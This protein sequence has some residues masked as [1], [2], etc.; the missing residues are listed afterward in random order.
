MSKSCTYTFKGPDGKEVS[1]TG[2]PAMKAYLATGG[3]EF[4][5]GE[6]RADLARASANDGGGTINPSEN[7]DEQAG[8]VRPEQARDGGGRYSSGGLAPLEG[9]PSV[10]GFHGPDPRLVEV[11]ERYAADN[12]IPLRRQAEYVKVDPER[13]ARI[14]GAYDAME[15]A[16]QDPAVRE[17]YESLIQQTR[18]QYDALADAGYSFWFVDL[19]NQGNLDYVST[20]WNAMRDIRANRRMGVFPTAEGFGT[21]ESFDPDANPLLADTGLR[22]PVGGPGGPL[23]PVLANDLF[24]AVHDAFGHGLEGAGFRARGEENAWQAHVRL[25]TGSAIGAIT[26]E[27]RGQNSWLNFGPYGERNRAA[28]VEDTVF[29]DQKTGLMPEWTWTEG[30]APD[31]DAEVAKS[32]D[33]DPRDN[34][35]FV[36]WFGDSVMTENGRPG[37]VPLVLYHGGFDFANAPAGKAVPKTG[38][39]GALG[40]GFYLTP[41]ES[42][43]AEYADENSGAVTQAY[44]RMLRPLEIRITA[45]QDP[46]IEALVSLGMD[47][48]KAARKVETAYEKYGYVGSEVKGL[49]LN[50]GYDGLVEYI[51]GRMSEVVAW[52]PTQ[53]KSATD[54]DG[55]YSWNPD[56]RRSVERSPLGFYSALAKGVEDLPTKQAPAGA[57]KAAIKGLVNKGAAKADEVEWSGV[58]DWLDLQQGKVS[59]DQVSEYLRQGG[60][61]VEE[62]MLGDN[63]PHNEFDSISDARKFMM[64]HHG[65]TRKEFDDDYEGWSDQQI[66]DS[67]NDLF[68]DA[69]PDSAVPTKYSQ[70]TLPGG[71]N[72]REVLLTLPQSAEAARLEQERDALNA[73][74]SRDPRYVD[75][76]NRIKGAQYKSK[77]WDQPNVLAHIRMDDRVDADGAKV[78]MVQELQSDWGQDGKRKGF[79]DPTARARAEEIG[80]EMN[81]LAEDREMPSNRIREE[82]RWL[83]LAKQRDELLRKAD[84][85]PAAPFLDSTEKWLNLALKRVMVMAAE[86]GYDKVAFVN[87]EQSA[88]R[89]DLSKQVESIGWVSGSGLSRDRREGA[90]TMTISYAKGGEI[91]LSVDQDGKVFSGPE[92]VIDRPLDEV[93]GKEIAAKIM[94]ADSGS[95]TGLDL[96]VG[97]S[98]MKTFYDTIVPAALKKLLPKVGGGQMGNVRLPQRL[99]PQEQDSFFEKNGYMPDEE[100]LT[101]PGF[102]VTDAMREKVSEGLPLF[103]RDR[104][105]WTDGRIDGLLRTHAYTMDDGRS[106]AYAGF[107]APEDFL[108]ATTPA[109]S[110]DRLESEKRPLSVKELADEDQPI[111]LLGEPQKDGTWKTTGHEGRHR[112]M[113]LRD[114]GVRRV[115]VVFDVGYGLTREPIERLY[116]TPQRWSGAGSA[117]GGFLVKGLVPISYRYA[118]ELRD[119]FAGDG[120]IRFSRERTDKPEFRRWFGNS[121]IVDE[122]GEP[123]VVYHQTKGDFSTFIPGGS[124]PKLSGPAIWARPDPSK[125]MS[126]HN[127]GTNRKGKFQPGSLDMPLYVRIENALGSSDANWRE[128][129]GQFKD[130][131]NSPWTLTQEF[132]AELKQAGYDGIMH[133][134]KSGELQEIAAFDPTQVKSAIGNSGAFDPANPDITKSEDRDD[135]ATSAWRTPSA[136]KFDNWVYKLQD[137]QIDTKRVVDEIR[138]VSGALADDLDVYL[139]EELFHGRAAKRTEDFVNKELRPLVDAMAKDGLKIEDLDTFLHARHARE[140]NAVIAQRN[141]E[142]QDG[143]SGMTN[144]DAADYFANLDEAQR[145]KLE[146]AAAK[147]D[148]ILAETRKMMVDYQL[149]S[150]DVIKGW[151]QMFQHYVPLMREDEGAGAG[152]GI[153]QGFSIKGREVKSRTGSTRKVVDIFANIAMQRERTI[154]RGEKNRVSQ[155]LHGLATANP[156]PDFWKVDQTPT[157][158]TFNPS[159]GLVED[160]PDPMFKTR[161]NVIVSKVLEQDEN[162]RVVAREKAVIFDEKNERAMRMATAL[163]NLDAAQL[164]GLMGASAAVTRY[165]AS[166]NTQYNPVFGIINLMRD[167]QGAIVNLNTTELKDDKLKVARGTMSAL[168]GIMADARKARRGEAGTSEWSA[169]WE[170][171]QS[172]GGQTGYR[173][174]FQTSADRAK[175]IQRALNPD[176]WM[177]SRWGRIFTAGGT[178]KVPLSVAMKGA[179]WLFD[180][181]GDYNLAMENGIRLSAYKV[182][183]DKGMSRERAASL[184]KNLTVNFNRKGQVGQQA[185]ALYAFF[186]AA[187]QGT[188]RLGQTLFE[189]EPGKPKTIRLSGLGKKIVYGGMLLGT[190]QA[191]ALA[192][193]GFSDDDPPDFVRERSLIFPTGWTGI[194]SERGYISIPMPLGLHVIPN[195]GRVTTEWALSGFKN[196]PQRVASLLGTFADSFNPIGNAGWSMQTLSPT[197]LDPLVALTENR[198]WQGRPIAKES[199][200]RDMPGPLLHR[201]TAT[202]WGK[203]I[204]ESI[205][206]LSGGDKYTRGVLSP[207]PD[208]V[209]YLI[210][211]LTGG[212][213]REISKVEQTAFGLVR[214]EEVPAYKMP[215]VGRLV[216]DSKSQASEGTAF[217]ANAQKLNRL[218]TEIKLLREDGKVAEAQALRASRPEAYLI[219]QANY[220]ERAIQR[221]RKEK[222]E[223]I[224]EGAPRER[225][226][227]IEEK[228]TARMAGLN[229]AMEALE[230]AR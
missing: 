38:N 228:I 22:W 140:A 93:L 95:L 70:Y 193:A 128:V 192:L 21:L 156:N 120:D 151:G 65:Q 42:R 180:L 40:V 149:E 114:A 166:I 58:N 79:A 49:A 9:A 113:A 145:R 54:N 182:A 18:A 219:T 138:G 214:G 136:S 16:P 200:N 25:F 112:M 67:A 32:A 118:S 189:M 107:V 201:D 143:G 137:K 13:A 77:H 124:D 196:T 23:A 203:L 3:L 153:G 75:L 161:E 208:Q 1:L 144:Q 80:A 33:R 162:G 68:R 173:Q 185:G 215:L 147:V 216:G 122:N 90:R 99:T 178:L 164:E 191:F 207:T 190:A 163:K 220:A 172:V 57:W 171:F 37:G 111:F 116:V 55:G 127:T 17:A 204:S 8:Q 205:N 202:S 109:D 5:L 19:G 154:V 53:I 211:Q 2:A 83:E 76:T 115:P 132:V 84:G 87:G 71:T 91:V 34:P 135:R 165:F 139:Q 155:A 195:V 103:S 222:S 74:S 117:Q 86:G 100:P 174:L 119:T 56:I 183:L 177:D 20:P 125:M 28:K 7:R 170:D 24:R 14:A 148:A 224:K 45:G 217:Y 10:P 110:V 97:G 41:D 187:M 229:R 158:P 88:D 43:A 101:Q 146:T 188:A 39:R 72:Y 198:D 89:Y 46:M 176:A 175:D 141:P 104:A 226:R 66:I 50:E 60:V 179:R 6:A 26:S 31:M 152:A 131:G 47:R 221:L 126:G 160:R 48:E 96:K 94:A 61:R 82:A 184:A 123:L 29:A 62:T 11:A 199:M 225:V 108:R 121:R 134:D 157:T 102:E 169:L 44:V 92:N 133:F 63:A 168:M 227:E 129:Y 85:V 106:K 223:L 69:Y 15:H 230:A 167:V 52:A 27:T 81:R 197:A 51:D 98:G 218:E 4:L 78:L 213:G 59:K 206:F 36:R 210:G 194:G 12:G 73:T 30:R 159:T 181:L 142:I 186:N 150:P 130:K 212:V 209:D 105:S 64:D 35:N